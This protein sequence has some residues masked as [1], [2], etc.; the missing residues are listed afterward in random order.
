MD[1]IY[2]VSGS[3]EKFNEIR[4]IANKC[5]AG[6]EIC[7]KKVSLEEVQGE[8]ET[9]LIRKKALEAFRLLRRPVL[10]EHTALNINAFNELPGL[11]TNYIYS[12]L[13]YEK[14]VKFCDCENNFEAAVMSIFCLCDGKRYYIGKGTEKGEIVRST[15]GID[16]KSG[17]GWDIIFIPEKDNPKKK[18]YACLEDR[19][20]DHLMRKRAWE[21]MMK[22]YQKE[23][24]LPSVSPS[25]REE[26]IEKLAQLIVDGK[27]MLFIGAGISA[28]VKFPSWKELIDKFGQELGYE[29][30]LFE[31]YGDYMMLA[32]YAELAHGQTWVHEQLQNT[33]R[34]TEEIETELY[35]SRIYKILEQLEFP[36]I[37][38]TNYDSLLEEYYRNKGRGK[39]KDITVIKSIE[40]MKNIR[41]GIPRIMKFHGDIEIEKSTVLSESEYFE[42]MDFSNFMDVQLQ[43]DMLQ[44][45][46]LFLGYSL[47]DINV[48]LLMY[49]ARKRVREHNQAIQSYI[50]TATPN[51][52]QEEVFLKNGIITITGEEEDKKTGTLDFLE[53]LLK[54][55]DELRSS[56]QNPQTKGSVCE[57]GKDIDA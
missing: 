49:L 44:Y 3:E 34:I 10:V 50:Y 4:S 21:N 9:N 33:F 52:V 40:D 46:M 24:S 57:Q 23:G 11:H 55:C 28:S 51:L 45:S 29:A 42:R 17:F 37:Y 38:T 20:S 43:A 14:I 18:T 36:I 12:K 54:K 27:V 31:S 32:E 1:R 30:D 13:G 35:N 56:T 47:S 22:E 19:K 6:W 39:N 15:D 26:N 25:K 53:S 2:F 8:Q 7:Q 5:G 48:K 16:E 41:P